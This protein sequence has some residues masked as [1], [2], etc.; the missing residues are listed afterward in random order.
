VLGKNFD[1]RWLSNFTYISEK[2]RRIIYT[3]YYGFFLFPH[4]TLKR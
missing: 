2:I 4:M 1:A 3:R